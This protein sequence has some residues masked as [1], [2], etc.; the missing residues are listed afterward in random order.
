[1]ETEGVYKEEFGIDYGDF[2]KKNAKWC[3]ITKQME[4][5]PIALDM[6]F[7]MEMMQLARLWRKEWQCWHPCAFVDGN[8]WIL[9]TF[10]TFEKMLFRKE[11][12][13]A[14]EQSHVHWKWKN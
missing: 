3:Q 8:G 14:T 1:M 10:S 2:G 5:S 13:D 9:A 4:M 6:S 12:S 11:E 7:P